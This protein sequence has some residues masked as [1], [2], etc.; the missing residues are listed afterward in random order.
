MVL[1]QEALDTAQEVRRGQ[2]SLNPTGAA[3]VAIGGGHG[4]SRSL[5]AICSYA[6][7][8]TAI[9]SVAD[10]GGSS[11]RLRESFSIPAP[12][13]IRRCLL[14]LTPRPSKLA[15]ALEH[16]FDSGELEGHAFGNVFL[17]ALTATTGDFVESV[18]YLGDLLGALGTVLPATASPVELVGICAGESIVGQ[19]KIMATGNVSSVSLLPPEVVAP[20]AALAA[21]A[22]AE[23]IVMGPGSLYTSV[24]AALVPA[25]IADAIATSRACRVYV[26]NLREQIPETKSYDV[27][28]HINALLAH[29]IQPDVV[30][31]DTTEIE[32]GTP[33]D[34]IE[35]VDTKLTS[36]QL[37]LHDEL[38]LGA[39]LSRLL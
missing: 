31:C 3:V 7:S 27:A 30:L 15:D 10:D 9:V 1:G 14:A 36:R 8:V 5:G 22:K 39:A 23:Q 33:P 20:P 38:L 6:R 26:C 32:L 35:I 19:A 11:G 17:A 12:G 18:G 4:L 28:A 25:G 2:R 16:R 21:I 13:D 29:G 34:G 37:A 24:L